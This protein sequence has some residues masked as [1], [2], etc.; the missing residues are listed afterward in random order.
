MNHF[1]RGN[2][3]TITIIN[4]W[5]RAIVCAVLCLQAGLVLAEAEY[6]IVTANEKGT[7]F[8]IGA[9]IAKYVAPDAVSAWELLTT[10]G[11]GANSKPLRSSAGVTFALFRA[12]VYHEFV[13]L[14][15]AQIEYSGGLI[16]T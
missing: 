6:K 5:L 1:A 14:E 11:S 15:A 16:Y 13:E 3:V 2:N 8:A 9:D 10:A 12:D 7:Y 4:N